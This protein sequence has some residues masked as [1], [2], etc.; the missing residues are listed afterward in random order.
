MQNIW[1]IGEREKERTERQEE[2]TREERIQERKEG[3][4]YTLCI[5]ISYKNMREM[6]C[7]IYYP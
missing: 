7:A 2:K 5:W 3:S 6:F 1:I 4:V